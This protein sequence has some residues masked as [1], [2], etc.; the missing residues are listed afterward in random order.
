MSNTRLIG[1]LIDCTVRIGSGGRGG[2][3]FFVAPRTVLTCAH[4]VRGTAPGAEVCVIWKTSP[5]RAAV[6]E[7]VA[8]LD[9]AVLSVEA[10]AHP[11]VL[12]GEPW[13]LDAPLYGYGYPVRNGTV[14]GDSIRPTLEGETHTDPGNREAALLRLSHTQIEP[15]FSGAPL[16]DRSRGA[17]VA[18]IKS[19]RDRESDLGGRAIPWWVAAARLTT[20][21]VANRAFHEA[22]HRWSAAASE[23]HLEI[24]TPQEPKLLGGRGEVLRLLDESR[25]VFVAWDFKGALPLP[26]DAWALEVQRSG[27]FLVDIPRRE[28]GY[29]EIWGDIVAARIKESSHL[30]AVVDAANANVC[31]EIGFA[32]GLQRKVALVRCG[33]SPSWTPE[34]VLATHEFVFIEEAADLDRLISADHGGWTTIAPPRT[35]GK[36]TLLLLPEKKLD[37][38]ITRVVGTTVDAARWR[39]FPDASP[40][41]EPGLLSRVSE[42]LSHVGR[43]IWITRRPVQPDAERDG[44]FNASN[45]IIAGY[46]EAVGIPLYVLHDAG[47]RRLVDVG[48]RE[49]PWNGVEA[50]LSLLGELAGAQDPSAPAAAREEWT[51]ATHA[52]LVPVPVPARREPRADVLT[53]QLARFAAAREPLESVAAAVG[54]PR[55]ELHGRTPLDQWHLLVSFCDRGGTLDALVDTVAAKLA[56]GGTA[57]RQTL[58]RA[59]PPAA[60]VREQVR[61]TL[62]EPFAKPFTSVLEGAEASAEADAA[63]LS[64]WALDRLWGAEAPKHLA[65][66]RWRREALAFAD[67]VKHV[68]EAAQARG[69]IDA[70][71]RWV[72]RALAVGAAA[73]ALTRWADEPSQEGQRFFHGILNRAN[74]LSETRL[75]ILS[76][77][78]AWWKPALPIALRWRRR[79]LTAAFARM[80]HLTQAERRR[81]LIRLNRCD[82]LVSTARNAP[83]WTADTDPPSVEWAAR[84]GN[85]QFIAYLLERLGVREVEAYF[86]HL[87][88]TFGAGRA[89]LLRA[90]RRIAEQEQPT[91]VLPR[92]PAGRAVRAALS[93]ATEADIRPILDDGTALLDWLDVLT[94]PLNDAQLHALTTLWANTWSTRRKKIGRRLATEPDLRRV[95]RT[96]A[97]ARRGWLQMHF[98]DEELRAGNANDLARWLIRGEG[99]EQ[100]RDAGDARWFLDR[101]R[102]ALGRDEGEG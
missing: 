10:E 16:L 36:E 15:G 89:A 99:Q 21:A 49:R 40:L 13:E 58:L 56:D 9:L 4:V 1:L 37:G 54:F 86:R 42:L 29:G 32:L 2:T 6:A 75:E 52:P 43:V 20:I 98:T 95:W 41:G 82:W 18:V 94:P 91:D 11:C 73:D 60:A 97:G 92:T 5:L 81:V 83:A 28:S 88:N 14:R 55:A 72:D 51:Q 96:L 93:G 17:V 33:G 101:W 48:H 85:G 63:Q 61:R 3:G 50:L 102:D 62:A 12:L 68:V 80:P 53:T 31:F 27:E 66:D 38:T 100:P 69:L 19:T 44:K 26:F 30:I 24:G 35:R 46:A 64:M 70:Q 65:L 7:I 57:L 34:T 71:H 45:A 23:Q 78:C 87:E 47:L 77:F 74:R 25:Q 90:A 67:S 79:T 39:V 8:E 22:D 84:S 59:S 76:R